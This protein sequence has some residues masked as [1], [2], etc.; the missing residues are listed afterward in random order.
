M[1]HER[2]RSEICYLA[3]LLLPS[4]YQCLLLTQPPQKSLVFSYDTELK[5]VRKKIG[6][7]KKVGVICT[8]GEKLLG[9]S[10]S[11]EVIGSASYQDS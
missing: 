11:T 9:W 4:I 1:L 6:L 7:S 5:R 10:T 3:S 8:I 2:M